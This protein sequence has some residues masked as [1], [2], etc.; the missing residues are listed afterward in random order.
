MGMKIE[1]LEQSF[2]AVAPKGQ[3]LVD[4]FYRRLFND[5]PAVMPL[6]EDV[7]LPRQ[8]LMLLA[9]LKLVV[10]NLRKPDVLTSALESMGSRHVDYG[11]RPEHYPA[12]GA[13]LL[14]SLA[15][16]AGEMWNDELE[17]AWSE[18]YAVVSQTMLAGAL[19]HSELWVT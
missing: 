7:D 3:Q 11:A 18:A 19:V 17:Q 14:T 9:A 8:K 12:V 16:V 5:Y 15:E 10:D 2:A 13:T 1:L 6:F 4:T